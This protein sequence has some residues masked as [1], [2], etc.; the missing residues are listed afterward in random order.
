MFFDPESSRNSEDEKGRDGGDRNT[1]SSRRPGHD[2]QA[3]NQIMLGA[4]LGPIIGLLLFVAV[5]W[6]FLP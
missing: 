4:F 2:T 6:W 5:V 1:P 3:V